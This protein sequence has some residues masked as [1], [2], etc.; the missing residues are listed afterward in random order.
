MIKFLI[1]L[2]HKSDR[3]LIT[4]PKIISI[5]NNLLANNAVLDCAV[6]ALKS[7]SYEIFFMPP[8][9]GNAALNTLA[10]YR[11]P[12][13]S[14]VTRSPV[15]QRRHA[16]EESAAAAAAAEALLANSRELDTQKEVVLGMLEKFVDANELQ[17]VVAL[18]LLRERCAQQM[19]GGAFARRMEGG[20]ASALEWPKSSCILESTR[21]QDPGVVYA[22][23]CRAMCDGRLGVHN[24]RDFYTLESC[25]KNYSKYVLADSKNFLALLQLLL[26]Q[27]SR[28]SHNFLFVYSYKVNK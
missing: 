7:L 1:Q 25:F 13:Q 26:T 6:L 3:K 17:H 22:L 21:L 16:A 28:C 19:D 23:I 24:W 27:V 10:D 14:P 15:Q 8:V 12:F 4:I 18:L 2:T 5:T 20:D 11:A 9:G